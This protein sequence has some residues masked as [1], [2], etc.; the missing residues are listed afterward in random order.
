MHI[1][2]RDESGT[3]YR[4]QQRYPKTNTNRSAT[5]NSVGKSFQN[6]LTDLVSLQ[7]S[8]PATSAQANASQQSAYVAGQTKS[9]PTIID[10]KPDAIA[11]SG[12]TA[13]QVA[14]AQAN[15][16]EDAY[17][18]FISVKGAGSSLYLQDMVNSYTDGNGSLFKQYSVNSF[19]DFRSA[20]SDSGESITR[21]INRM[22]KY[23]YGNG[24][25]SLNL[26][27]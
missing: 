24:R 9:V 7:S 23:W 22:G 17:E 2:G 14:E 20:F 1:R 25:L 21:Y 10:W 3:I 5:T 6:V 4:T 16:I 15:A 26:P 8:T 12:W 11:A 18:R 27:A 19:D 13:E